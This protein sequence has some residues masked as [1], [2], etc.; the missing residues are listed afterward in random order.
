MT[1]RAGVEV[2]GNPCNKYHLL[3]LSYQSLRKQLNK[4]GAMTITK[5]SGC[6]NL[7]SDSNNVY[8]VIQCIPVKCV[9]SK[10]IEQ[11]Q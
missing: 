10:I 9:P 4:N 6:R 5:A 7:L 8:K 2:S 11:D 1:I 3:N